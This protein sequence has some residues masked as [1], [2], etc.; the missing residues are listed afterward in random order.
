MKKYIIILTLI[1]G[2]VSFFAC[3]KD[4]DKVFISEDPTTSVLET[5]PSFDNFLL[6]NTASELTFTWSAADFGF[7]SATTYT[8]QIDSATKVFSW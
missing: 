2:L 5:L 3:E 4:E 7:Q 8:L 6:E 1:L